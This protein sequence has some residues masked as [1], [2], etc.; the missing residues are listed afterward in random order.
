MRRHLIFDLDGTL[1]DSCAV[2]CDILGDMLVERGSAHRID[3]A[4]ARVWMSTGGTE[5]VVA[6]LGP[7]CG[8]PEDEIAEFRRRYALKATPR[9]T[10]FPHVAAGL[11]QMADAGYNLSICSNKPQNLVEKVL[12]D[13]GLSPFFSSVVGRRDDLLPK[14]ASEMLERVRAE[15]AAPRNE[16][17]LIGDSEVDHQAAKAGGIPF[18]FVSYGYARADYTPPATSFDCFGKLTEAL[19][20]TAPCQ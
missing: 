16:C 14:P 20:Q 19:I 10:L 8:D 1:V 11:A 9:E 4:S 3:P 12:A 2:C 6:L 17:L 13:T 15:L 7:A 18:M 5:M